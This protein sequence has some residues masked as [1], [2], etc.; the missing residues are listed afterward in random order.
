MKD[1]ISVFWKSEQSGLLSW[2]HLL[3]MTLRPSKPLYYLG[4]VLVKKKSVV[5]ALRLPL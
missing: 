1:F 2:T 3:S 4:G 5:L